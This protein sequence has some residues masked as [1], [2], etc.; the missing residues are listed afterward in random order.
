[1][2]WACCAWGLRAPRAQADTLASALAL[3]IL[4]VLSVAEGGEQPVPIE[5]GSREVRADIRLTV[6]VG[7]AAR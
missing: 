5:S 4:R 1:M 3:R 2:S 6:E 7:P